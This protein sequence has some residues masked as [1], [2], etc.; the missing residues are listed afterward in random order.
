VVANTALVPPKPLEFTTYAYDGEIGGMQEYE[1]R[2]HILLSSTAEEL[3]SP[4]GALLEFQDR[5]GQSVRL[6]IGLKASVD[7]ASGTSAI[8]MSQSINGRSATPH[9]S[10][11][12]AGCTG[13]MVSSR[14]RDG[15]R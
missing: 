12:S 2:L 5:I 6:P 10:G 9:S 7:G 14:S 13:P 11:W 8:S 1:A 15:L 3:T 4:D